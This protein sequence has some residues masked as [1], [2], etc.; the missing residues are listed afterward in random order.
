MDLKGE[1]VIPANRETVWD[2]LMDPEILR[3]CIPGCETLDG[4]VAEGFT[5]TVKLG[6]GPVKATFSGR[7]ELIDLDKPAS[8]RIVGSGSGGAAGLASGAATVALTE[9]A[10]G[11]QLVYA[12][13]AKISGKLA[14]LG[15]RLI[16]A[17]SAKLAAQFF[18][19]F[20]A[21][22]ADETA[23]SNA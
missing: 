4:S 3:R 9:A 19:T 15:S 10:G 2:K 6:I 23:A 20:V 18:G 16:T 12:A 22:M 7:V 11:T 1:F 13:D 8:F 17:T 21:I 5:A 14:Q